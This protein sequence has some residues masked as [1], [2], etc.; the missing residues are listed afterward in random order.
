M[1]RPQTI[2]MGNLKNRLWQHRMLSGKLGY[3]SHVQGDGGGCGCGGITMA[4]RRRVGQDESS[5]M[6]L[7]RGKG[8]QKKGN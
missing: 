3:S 5:W 7:L 4:K 6:I 1:S 8:L 2:L